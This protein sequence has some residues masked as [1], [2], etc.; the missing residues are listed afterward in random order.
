MIDNQNANTRS[1]LDFLVNDKISSLENE[2]QAL[3]LSASQ[4]AQNN[5]LVS[6]LRP[7]PVPAFA[8]PAPYQFTS[9]G[10]CGC[11]SNGFGGINY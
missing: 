11:G 4:Q 8:V 2:N 9:C 5:Y 7:A 3:R 6:T 1:I 10:G